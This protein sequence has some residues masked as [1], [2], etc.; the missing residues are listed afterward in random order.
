MSEPAV[1][2]DHCVLVVDDEEGVREALREV[3]EMAGCSAMLAANGAEA[4]ELLAT[5]RPCLIILDLLMPVMTGTELLEAMG[6]L[7]DLATIAVVISTSAPGRA[8]PGLP[9]L[10]KPV[11]IAAVWDCMRRS[12]HCTEAPLPERSSSISVP[13]G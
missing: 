12:C 1:R 11:D 8:P 5:C 2:D 3:V 9:V 13:C 4:L 7:P 10:P 6:R